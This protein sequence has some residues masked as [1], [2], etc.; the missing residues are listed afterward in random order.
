MAPH[1]EKF[2]KRCLELASL[3]KKNKQSPVGSVIVKDNKVIASGVEGSE[4]LPD[5]L[6]HAEIIAILNAVKYTGS[7][8]LSEC[9]LY[10]TVEPC[11]MCSYLIRKTK[12][13][14]VV[15]GMETEETGGINST[16]PFLKTGNF[17][18]WNK[19]PEIIG[20]ILREECKNLFVVASEK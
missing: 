12:I 2:M 11:F 18:K 10:T 9:E 19:P 17:T 1:P 5:M 16:F 14:R 15:Y 8:D 3:A 20:G 7:E 13:R 4:E 6:A